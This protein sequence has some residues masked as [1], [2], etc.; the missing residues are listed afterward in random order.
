MNKEKWMYQ[1][2]NSD[3][4]NGEEFE[5]KEEALKEGMKERGLNERLRTGQQESVEIS[6]IDVD[7]LLENVAEN[8]VC[9]VGE[10]GEDFLMDVSKEEQKELE[11]ELNKVFFE[12][13]NKYG[14]NPSFFKIV[15]IEEIEGAKNNE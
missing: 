7:L 3:I 9:E 12:W 10:V 6:G 15:N 14:Y 11:E 1:L 2:G 13:V 5:T 4:W 8:T